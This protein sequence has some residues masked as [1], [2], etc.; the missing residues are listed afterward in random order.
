M[1]KFL[2]SSFLSQ[3]LL[4]LV[5]LQVPVLSLIPSPKVQLPF[6]TLVVLC[7]TISLVVFLLINDYRKTHLTR[8]AK[9]IKKLPGSPHRIP[10][11]GQSY[12]LL[13]PAWSKFVTLKNK[14]KLLINTIFVRHSGSLLKLFEKIWN[15]V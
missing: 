10:F 13:G 7:L 1:E 9:M 12:L 3:P 4:P 8:I 2:E 14:T 11:I 5:N 6:D 15:S